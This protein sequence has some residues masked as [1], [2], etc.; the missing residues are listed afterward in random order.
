[1][2]RDALKRVLDELIVGFFRGKR[3]RS[4]GYFQGFH[5]IATV[6]LLTFFSVEAL[7]EG[8]EGARIRRRT[9]GPVPASAKMEP[10]EAM[11]EEETEVRAEEC[12]ACLERLSCFRIRDGM[13]K[14]L[15]PVMGNLR[16]VVVE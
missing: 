1:M 9:S 7:L 2:E 5:D 10:D 14:G 13:G 11:S 12:M 8:I 16:Y 6:V 3:G 4:F 15:E